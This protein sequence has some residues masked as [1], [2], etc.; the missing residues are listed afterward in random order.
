MKKIITLFLVF[1]FI[2]PAYVFAEGMNQQ[3][4][5]KIQSPKEDKYNRYVTI[6]FKDKTTKKEYLLGET[7]DTIT[8]WRPFQKKE[9]YNKGDIDVVISANSGILATSA[10]YKTV[11]FKQP[12][13]ELT[14]IRGRTDH[15]SGGLGL[16]V[17][18]APMFFITGLYYKS[19][20]EK[21]RKEANTYFYRTQAYYDLLKKEDEANFNAQTWTIA[22]IMF[23][24]AGIFTMANS[25]DVEQ[26]VPSYTQN[27]SKSELPKYQITAKNINDAPI[28]VFNYNF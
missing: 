24:A 28:L 8:M 27:L 14:T 11:I 6:F 15:Y 12:D 17:I 2:F 9:I 10:D 3:T 16:A 22:A 4:I 5:K 25:S 7:D 26:T 21:H 19:E 1:T 18:T 13:T 20:A 23:A